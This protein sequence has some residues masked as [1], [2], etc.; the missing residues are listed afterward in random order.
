MGAQGKLRP[1]VLLKGRTEI[2]HDLGLDGS[3]ISRLSREMDMESELSPH[4]FRGDLSR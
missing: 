1:I 3:E 4:L 2:D